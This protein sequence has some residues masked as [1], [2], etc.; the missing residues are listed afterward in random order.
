MDCASALRGGK[1]LK[2]PAGPTVWA[3]KAPSFDRALRTKEAMERMNQELEVFLEEVERD[4][5][6][7]SFVHRA[8]AKIGEFVGDDVNGAI[9]RIK[10]ELNEVGVDPFG[11]D[12]E[13]GRVVLAFAALLHRLYFRSVVRGVEDL[14]RGRSLIIANHSGQLPFDGMMIAAAMMLD[15][16]PPR[17]PRAMVERWTVELPFVSVLFPRVGQVLGSPENARRLLRRGE[18]LIVFPEGSRGISKTY[19]ER[20]QLTEFG[21]GFMRLALETNTP[22][23]PVSVVGAEEQ[24]ISIANFRRLARILGM[25]AFPIIPQLF[26]GMILPIPVRYR[27]RF[28]KPLHFEGDPDADDR[29][30]EA[31][32]MSVKAR[33]EEQ[34][35]KDLDER[36]G[37][38]F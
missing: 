22:I 29:I 2:N 20:Y 8:A 3:R 33:I 6:A 15:A 10:L 14:P 34:I 19:R 17:L 23:V 4:A 25:P 13:T 32:V 5:E 21:L 36:R 12:R 35:A 31:K 7:R 11:F 9:D 1:P 26:V 37:L 24:Y 27:I 30:I 16:N 18:S 28:G 38:F